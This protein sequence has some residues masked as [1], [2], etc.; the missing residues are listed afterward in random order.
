MKKIGL[1]SA[2]L[3]A[4][5]L[6]AMPAPRAGLL[7]LVTGTVTGITGL[8]D[9]LFRSLR[10]FTGSETIKYSLHY[11]VTGNRIATTP[12]SATFRFSGPLT[13]ATVDPA[14]A[15]WQ[16]TPVQVGT[17][18]S[19][20]L[21]FRIKPGAGQPPVN[22]DTEVSSSNI[23]VRIGNNRL[24][25]LLDNPS[26][27]LPETHIPFTGRMLFELGPVGTT[28]AIRPWH[29]RATG[30][31]GLQSSS[32]FGELAGKRGAL[33]TSGTFH[34]PVQPLSIADIQSATTLSG[35]SN[36]TLVMH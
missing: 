22:T 24:Q 28:D 16:A 35:E 29:Y 11:R 20:D 17:I 21:T 31:L 4:A 9:P 5:S 30:C 10:S 27:L 26:T 3:L 8:L 13:V 14:D 2:T 32:L 6:L 18:Q 1:I 19:W 34:F 36:F 23:R 15:N 33:C 12:D 7:N 25:Q